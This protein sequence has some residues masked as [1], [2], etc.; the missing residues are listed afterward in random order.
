[1]YPG[2][3]PGTFCLVEGGSG[4]GQMAICF[5]P[6]PF[7]PYQPYVT[8][9]RHRGRPFGDETDLGCFFLLGWVGGGGEGGVVGGFLHVW[10]FPGT[11]FR[12]LGTGDRG[13]TTLALY[14]VTEKA[15]E[16]RLVR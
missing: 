14:L 6:P 5:K 8:L 1:M 3:G 7:P 10:G 13:V 15:K 16:K 12:Y 4:G 11:Y 9:L 2:H